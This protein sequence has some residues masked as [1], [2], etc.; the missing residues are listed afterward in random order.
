V[1]LTGPARA[2]QELSLRDATIGT[3]VAYIPGCLL[4]SFMGTQGRS[5]GKALLE[6]NYR[7]RVFYLAI[8]AIIVT[9]TALVSV[10]VLVRRTIRRKQQGLRKATAATHY[11][12]TANAAGGAAGDEEAAGVLLVSARDDRSKEATIV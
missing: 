8:I 12:S 6:G 5:I 4:F 3:A 10:V 2:S 9:G 1:P 11:G 7:S